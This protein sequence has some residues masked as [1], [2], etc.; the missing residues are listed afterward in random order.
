MIKTFFKISYS[1]LSLVFLSISILS[2]SLFQEHGS[3]NPGDLI[4]SWEL[5]RQTGALQDV[6]PQERITFRTD[7]IA[8]L[9]CPNKPSITRHYSA[10][11]GILT[12][13]ETGISFDFYIF[14]TTSET[15]LELY[16]KNV[17]RNLF[18]YKVNLTN[19][20]EPD[21]EG[22]GANNSSEN[23]K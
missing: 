1:I 7:S 5:Y 3:T 16:G 6:C 2:C 9:Q 4:G 8:T 20:T 13:K 15:R 21:I 18:Y 11:N 23:I 22:S 19:S 10:K 12:Y 14:K 17:S